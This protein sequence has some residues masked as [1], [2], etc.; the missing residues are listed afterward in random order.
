MNGV[1]WPNA[2]PNWPAPQIQPQPESRRRP[3]WWR[4]AVVAVGVLVGGAFLVRCSY[5]AAGDLCQRGKGFWLASADGTVSGVGVE[6]FGGLEG[7]AL[8]QPVVAIAPTLNRKGYWLLAGDGGVFAKGD[9]GFYGSAAGKT[10]APFVDLVPTP[11]GRGY[12]VAGA[13]G[14]VYAFGDA[15]SPAGAGGAPVTPSPPVARGKVIAL[16]SSELATAGC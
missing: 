10:G 6:T 3:W 14:T 16:A 1:P 2:V 8:A 15:T 9:A 7:L 5:D 11:S 4:S 13:T 12:W